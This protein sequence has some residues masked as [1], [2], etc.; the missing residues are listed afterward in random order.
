MPIGITTCN[1]TSR[2]DTQTKALI[3]SGAEGEFINQ[4]DAWLIRTNNIWLNIWL[5]ELI[6]VLNVDGT[7]NKWGTITHYTE[8][9]MTISN[10]IWKQC[11]YITR[12]GKQKIIFGFTWFNKWNPDINWQTGKIKWW[13]PEGNEEWMSLSNGSSI[14]EPSDKTTWTKPS[15]SKPSCAN[16]MEY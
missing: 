5:K 1:D 11:F 13:Q 9:N 14:N 8:L 4:N 15:A 10:C 2:I 6:P 16:Y 3:D 12:L 7:W